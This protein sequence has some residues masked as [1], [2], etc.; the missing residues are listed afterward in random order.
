MGFVKRDWI[1]WNPTVGPRENKRASELLALRLDMHSQDKVSSH[2][3]SSD[4]KYHGGS[5]IASGTA[6]PHTVSSAEDDN[7]FN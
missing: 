1:T 5:E 7:L 3:T 4:L 2:E 6:G